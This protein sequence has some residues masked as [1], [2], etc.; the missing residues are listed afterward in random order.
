VCQHVEGQSR[1]RVCVRGRK[2]KV[3]WRALTLK[4][5]ALQSESG[6]DLRGLVDMA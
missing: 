3:K 1:Y 4:L 2:G 6:M 5:G